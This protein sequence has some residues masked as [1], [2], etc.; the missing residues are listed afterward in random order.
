MQKPIGFSIITL[1]LIAEIGLYK[2]YWSCQAAIN[3][4]ANMGCTEP[5]SLLPD[6]F[7]FVEFGKFFVEFGKMTI[8]FF[9]LLFIP[10]IFLSVIL[11]LSNDWREK[12]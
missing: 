8:P 6:A 9:M 10:F 2:L 3:S 1:C 4:Y 11:R 12:L 5:I 7:F